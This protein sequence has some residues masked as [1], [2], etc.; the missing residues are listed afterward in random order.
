M[1]DRPKRLVLWKMKTAEHGEFPVETRDKVNWANDV[2]NTVVRDGAYAEIPWHY[3]FTGTGKRPEAP[4]V[5][6]RE[7]PG[8]I[9]DLNEP[10]EVTHR[11]ALEYLCDANGWTLVDAVKT[12]EAD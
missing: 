9:D 12:G 1:S 2:D 6:C 3:F 7:R 10:R 5:E 8:P 11:R 4:K